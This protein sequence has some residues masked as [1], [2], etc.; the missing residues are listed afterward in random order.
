M[1]VKL[2]K[3]ACICLVLVS[4][5]SFTAACKSKAP[6]F[7]EYTLKTLPKAG[8]FI[9]KGDLFRPLF[10]EGKTFTAPPTEGTFMGNR[11]FW[12]HGQKLSQIPTLE[13]GDELILRSANSEIEESYVFE[14][15]MNRGYTLGCALTPKKT[16]FAFVGSGSINEMSD[17]FK[18]L[19]EIKN[20]N[21]YTVLEINTNPFSETLLDENGMVLGL[22]AGKNYMLGSFEGTVYREV[23]I[24]ADTN[25][26]TSYSTREKDADK[27]A[28]SLTRKGYAVI[29]LPSNLEPGLYAVNGYG[30]FFVG[31]PDGQS[32]DGTEQVQ[33]TATEESAKSE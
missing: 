17:A 14:Y 12:H 20:L 1:K 22:E 2:I 9:R 18:V 13:P 21:A 27:P 10:I 16:G 15:L 29:T 25:Y 5:M 24:M 4:M 28:Y 23:T 6:E 32:A 3:A 30:V 8:Y 11:Y 31:G 19:S 7:E 33:E 26:Y